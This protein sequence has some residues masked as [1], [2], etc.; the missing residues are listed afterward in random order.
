[1]GDEKQFDK[2]DEKQFDQKTA[3]SRAIE[4]YSQFSQFARIS[5]EFASLA[6]GGA[7]LAMLTFF[8]LFLLE[9]LI[10]LMQM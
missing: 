3:Y 5:A 7:A 2:K 9:T 4:D 6:N 1:M 8:R 10:P